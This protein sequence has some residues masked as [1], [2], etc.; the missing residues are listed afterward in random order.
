M[1]VHQLITRDKW[2][3]DTGGC[4]HKWLVQVYPNDIVRKEAAKRVR[5]VIGQFSISA[6]NDADE[7]TFEE[8][9]AALVAAN[10]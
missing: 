1:K 8:V 9:H 6:W 2:T 10:V 3:K 5:G 7:R 4:V